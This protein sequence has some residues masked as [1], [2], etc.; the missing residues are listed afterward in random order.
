MGTVPSMAVSSGTNYSDPSCYDILGKTR[1]ATEWKNHLYGN[2]VLSA[3]FGF[4]RF[5]AAPACTRTDL[6]Q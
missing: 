1:L 4:D 3:G 2:Y 5:V 6:G